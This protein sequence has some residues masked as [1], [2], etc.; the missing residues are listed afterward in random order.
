ML[1]KDNHLYLLDTVSENDF[2]FGKSHLC[3]SCKRCAAKPEKDGGCSKVLDRFPQRNVQEHRRWSLRHS[4]VEKYS[5]IKLGY[6]KFNYDECFWVI[7]CSNFE[8]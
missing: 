2:N 8:K 6:E 3:S 1:K 5:F 4:R 7:E